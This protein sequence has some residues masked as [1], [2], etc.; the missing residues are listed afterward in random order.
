LPVDFGLSWQDR[1]P[2]KAAGEARSRQSR[3]GLTDIIVPYDW[4]DEIGRLKSKLIP[5][6]LI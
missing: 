2:A 5:N 4:V 6:D 1:L 3:K